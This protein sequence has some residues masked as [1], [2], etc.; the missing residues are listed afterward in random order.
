MNTRW[1][2]SVLI[3]LTLLTAGCGGIPLE[4]GGTLELGQ[5]TVETSD[6]GFQHE[7][8]RRF[9]AINSGGSGSSQLVLTEKTQREIS[10]LNKDGGVA[11]HRLN[12]ILEYRLKHSGQEER[13]GSFTLSQILDNDD[14]AHLTVR[15]K[16][17][18]FYATAR[19][20]SINN[21]IAE[22]RFLNLQ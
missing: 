12:Y 19:I 18:R 4:Q 17:D 1:L 8:Q 16:T 3:A 7:V 15:A 10:S 6:P 11:K 21:L 13:M 9:D 20:D 2:T 22:L 14:N 5:L